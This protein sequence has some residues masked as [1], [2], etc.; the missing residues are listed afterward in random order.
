MSSNIDN[1]KL[2][3][4]YLNQQ[5]ARDDEFRFLEIVGALLDNLEATRGGTE[6][7]DW[8]LLSEELKSI[9]LMASHPSWEGKPFPD[10]VDR[11]TVIQ[12]DQLLSVRDVHDVLVTMKRNFGSELL[13]D[14]EVVKVKWMKLLFKSYNVQLKDVEALAKEIDLY[15]LN[16]LDRVF[17]KI[18]SF[19][20]ESTL[21]FFKALNEADIDFCFKLE[22]LDGSN[23]LS[24]TIKSFEEGEISLYYMKTQQLLAKRGFSESEIA[25]IFKPL[26]Q[27]LENDWTLIDFFTAVDVIL[28]KCLIGEEV[29][30]MRSL[31]NCFVIAIDYNIQGSDFLLTIN[32][33]INTET[34]KHE[35]LERIFHDK[36]LT[37]FGGTH[38]KCLPELLRDIALAN[39]WNDEQ[40]VSNLMKDYESVMKALKSERSFIGKVV[41]SFT[42]D[43]VELWVKKFH[44][45]NIK[46]QRPEGVALVMKAFSLVKGYAIRDVQLLSLLLLYQSEVGTLAQ[47]NTGEGKTAIIAMLAC[48]FC[49]EGKK[50]DV[51]K[52]PFKL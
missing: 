10:I 16:V 50:V 34:F 17:S 24:S 48:L 33:A 26:Y 2:I 39:G 49:L 8:L 45:A 43:D 51:G 11:L 25:D 9:K 36:S 23:G 38:Q 22:L 44:E 28:R 14:K 41:D 37:K 4:D 47:V 1:K 13:E 18:E 7:D 30:A 52:F 3:E 27:M 12:E 46:P 21:R 5:D 35:E 6:A 42:I 31:G 15:P 40:R 19:D 20:E 32:Q 29:D